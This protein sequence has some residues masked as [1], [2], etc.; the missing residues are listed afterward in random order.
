MRRLFRLSGWLL[1]VKIESSGYMDLYNA[2]LF[3]KRVF[4]GFRINVLNF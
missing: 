4:K 2:E 3:K 1:I